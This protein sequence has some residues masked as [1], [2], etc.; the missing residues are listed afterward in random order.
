M[1]LTDGRRFA[2]DVAAGVAVPLAL[3]RIDFVVERLPS[4]GVLRGPAGLALVAAA[5]FVVLWRI[6]G[7]AFLSR[8][9][10]TPPGVWLVA[11]FLIYAAVGLHYA[12]GLP[13][14]GDEPHYLV[15]AQSL[16]RDLDLDLQDE[17]ESEEW[18]EFTPGPLRP[19]WGAPRSDGRPFP[20]HSPGLPLLLA[21]AYAAWGRSG[22]V[23]LMALV[24]AAAAYGCRQLAFAVTNDREAA[25]WA[26]IA[27]AGPPL[28]FYSFLAYT[29]GPSALF[30]ALAL[31]LL[32]RGP[33]ASAAA[34]AAL[35]ASLLPWLHLKM[36]PAAAALG[37]V[38]AV[39]LRGRS[40]AA[41]AGVSLVMV[42]GFAGYYASVFGVPSPLAI[43]GGMP[44][45]ARVYTWRA[46]AGLLLDRSFGLLPVAPVFLLA[47]AG[48]TAVVRRRASWS[49]LLLALAVL[50]PALTWRMWWG[51]Q[52]PPTRL[53]VPL[54]PF[55]AVA[56]A[57]RIAKGRHGLVRW[58]PAL[59]AIGL[60]LGAFAI[61][62]PGARLLLNVRD[63]P[64]R[65]WAALSGAVPLGD[66]LPSLTHASSRDTRVALVWLGAL[67]L[68]LLLDKLAATRRWVDGA[69][70]SFGS[71]VALLLLVGVTIDVGVGPRL[72]PVTPAVAERTT[73]DPP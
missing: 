17:Y 46:P 43:Y 10:R 21:P 71:A 13:V 4:F 30:A 61:A 39:R 70:A 59:T 14:T 54:L 32:L 3:S 26:W 72:S 1:R 16:W 55:L 7:A 35:C 51:G 68:L 28:A 53:L 66:Y 52:C 42:A 27:V 64:T 12:A 20:A 6:S 2:M 29:E 9:A 23:V 67:G 48:V 49:H 40:L 60:A 50:A 62:E 22:V 34:L 65:L 69:F 18:R 11:S 56:L 19:H 37:I 36:V 15:M 73:S 45:D 41:F 44:Q 58:L 57:V 25:A 47:L 33:G 31:L 38:A 63:R 24:A 5:V 8:V